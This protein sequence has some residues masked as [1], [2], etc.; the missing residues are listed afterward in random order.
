MASPA[1]PPERHRHTRARE[2]GL[3]RRANARA[4]A[5]GRAVGGGGVATR[6]IAA[7]AA[8]AAARS[9]GGGG[10]AA[11][12]AAMAWGKAKV[13]DNDFYNDQINELLQEDDSTALRHEY[14]KWRKHDL[15]RIR[16]AR[17]TARTALLEQARP[18][19][20]AVSL[21]PAAAVR[22]RPPPPPGRRGRQPRTRLP[23][24]M[25][26]LVRRSRA[27]RLWCRAPRCS[28]SKASSRWR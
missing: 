13:S 16:R 28:W 17:Q 23:R 7:A 19:A 15:P 2:S 14:V 21:P 3:R 1:P 8:A 20:A 12:A 6:M 22:D 10:G 5:G 26:P 25:P 24:L 11:A 27:A 9:A 4:A 18:P